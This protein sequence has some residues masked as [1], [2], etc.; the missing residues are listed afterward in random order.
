[1]AHQKTAKVASQAQGS[2]S[3][4]HQTKVQG[5]ATPIVESFLLLVKLVGTEN[6]T[7][8]RFLCVS[9]RMK[10][11]ELHDVLQISLGWAD[12]HLYKFRIATLLPAGKKK[13]VPFGQYGKDLFT[14]VPSEDDISEFDDHPTELDSLVTLKEIFDSTEYKGK[15]V[16]VYEYD[17]GD[18]WEHE[19]TFLGRA[20]SSLKRSLNVPEDRLAFCLGGEGHPSA[21]DCGGAYG[22]EQL[23]EEMLEEGDAGGRKEWYKESCMNGDPEGLEP[24]KW[25]IDKVNKDLAVLDLSMEIHRCRFVHY[26]PASIN[27]LAFSHPSGNKGRTPASLRLAIGRANGDIE[28]WNPL[29]GSWLHESTL[30][31]GK[32]RT[33][34]GLVWTQ[35]PGELDK[36]NILKP[37]KLRLFSIGFSTVV[38]E[39]DLENG[40]PLRHSSGNY[41]EVWCLA[42][43]PVWHA[44][45]DSKSAPSKS[46]SRDQE[47]KGQYLAAGCADGSVVILSTEDEDLVFKRT[48]ARPSAK[49]SR[50][51]SITFQN[52][53]IVIAGYANSTIRVY[54]I[55]SG[56]IKHAMSLGT[57]PKGG[58]K[59]ILVWSVKCLPNG[60]IVSGDS[61]GEVRFW[62]SKNY[63]FSQRIKSHRADVLSIET[64]AEGTVVIS[65]G[66]DRRTTV[67][68]RTGAG[69]SK[70]HRR[71]GEVGHRRFHTHDV[72]A[73]ATF[74]SKKLSVIASGGLDT[75]LNVIPLREFGFDY[76][77]GISSIPQFPILQSAPSKRLILAWWGRELRIW[78]IGRPQD[79]LNFNDPESENG[80]GRKLVS[81]IIIQDDENITSASLSANGNLLAVSTIASVKIFRLGARNSDVEDA[82]RVSKLETTK[83]FANIGA[84]LVQ[85][86]PDC[87]WLVIVS[88]EGTLRIVRV[89]QDI[90]NGYSVDSKLYT[91]RRIERRTK[92]VAGLGNYE[93]IVARAAFSSDSKILVV[94][95]LSGHLDSWVLSVNVSPNPRPKRS[96]SKNSSDTESSDSDDHDEDTD[97]DAP[98]GP[99]W[100]FNPKSS[101]L[102]KLPSAPIILSFRPQASPSPPLDTNSYIALPNGTYL[103]STPSEDRL[104]VLTAT[105]Q[106]YEFEVLK[107]A[108]SPWS[109]RNPP[110]HFPADFKGVKD[111]GMGCVWDT[112]ESR[113]RI[114]L[115]GSTWLWMFSLAHDFPPPASIDTESAPENPR[116]RKHSEVAESRT[117]NS[118]AGD[119]IRPAEIEFGRTWEFQRPRDES[120]EFI[121]SEAGGEEEEGKEEEEE[122]DDARTVQALRRAGDDS[123][124][125][126]AR[127]SAQQGTPGWHT[128]KYRPV[129]GI[130]AL[131]G[132][133]SAGLEVVLVERPMWEL[134]L[135]PSFAGDQDWVK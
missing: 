58:P 132:G 99:C 53:D 118:G 20:D 45:K 40:M 104:F 109:R 96:P 19:I 80:V 122:Y 62:D 59:E 75:I 51:L 9:S 115:Y 92:I 135:P 6:P 33:I 1:M 11:S 7:I 133:R 8:T 65:T 69:K 121:E 100:I 84:R 112:H 30:R 64:N 57:G 89:D 129:M 42:A 66:I 101:L 54:D 106:A 119:R 13:P 4:L 76:H 63:T 97:A 48:L 22:W 107:G 18:S 60:T 86:S 21:E 103:E 116:K 98:D 73:I 38:T 46:V 16:V 70:E 5:Q 78:R 105:H 87:R 88:R 32:D 74:E 71:W 93:R 126:V 17:L 83:S 68:K 94:G 56:S 50:V 49:K 34:E 12:Y 10:F 108:L 124:G 72:K 15:A 44:A 2:S 67:Y 3:K 131:E 47:F 102:P 81:K 111:R 29:G 55:R 113:E 134:D 120:P 130:V 127:K 128:H 82:L 28:I 23:K 37:G 35:E 41:G 125:A 26:P 25:N 52:R 43:Q 24:Y 39:W 61:S 90:N 95:D 31:G 79:S 14:L 123:D 77:R 36:H 114:W 117:L 91:L 110:T 85:F 27:A